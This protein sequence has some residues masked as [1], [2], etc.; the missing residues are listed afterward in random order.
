MEQDKI[1]VPSGHVLRKLG[2]NIKKKFANLLKMTL[3]KCLKQLI[4]FKL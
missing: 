1:I 3:F 4:F 2:G